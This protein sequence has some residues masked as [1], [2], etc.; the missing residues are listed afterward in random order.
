ME[1]EGKY[2]T[3][4]DPKYDRRL[5]QAKSVQ[6][7]IYLYFLCAFA[8]QRFVSPPIAP[9]YY[10]IRRLGMTTLQPSNF[11]GTKSPSK[12]VLHPDPK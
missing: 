7:A 2:Y 11:G 1:R 6:D 10:V 4:T 8:D 3:V 9:K 5:D 12:S